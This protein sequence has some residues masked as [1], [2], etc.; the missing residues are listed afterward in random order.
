MLDGF[1]AA[2]K[3]RLRAPNRAVTL[4]DL[5]THTAGFGYS[6]TSADI[7][8]YEEVTGLAA[9]GAPQLTSAP[10]WG[11][12]PAEASAGPQHGAARTPRS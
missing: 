8:K 6:F 11:S 12:D 5:L 4:K 2:G 1:D 7:K 3:P 10:A 9:D